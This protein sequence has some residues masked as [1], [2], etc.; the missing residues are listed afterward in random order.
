MGQ[1]LHAVVDH[2]PPVGQ[3][4]LDTEAEEAEPGGG[5]DHVRDLLDEEDDDRADG[6]GQDVDDGDAPRGHA[7]GPRRL[8]EVAVAQG[9][10][11]RPGQA[12]E[13]RPTA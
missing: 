8:H 1:V 7:H 12:A 2:F 6:I 11:L 9:Q 13:A 5:E 10:V 3:R 4:V